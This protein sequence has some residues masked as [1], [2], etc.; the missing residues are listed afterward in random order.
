MLFLLGSCKHHHPS[1]YILNCN[2]IIINNDKRLET[3]T[4]AYILGEFLT[5]IPRPRE[6]KV[7]VAIH[8]V[9]GIDHAVHTE[10]PFQ[11]A[12]DLVDLESEDLQVV[13]V[14]ARG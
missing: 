11:V 14:V 9:P 13:P 12:F 2:E 3:E 7:A 5:A 1:L 10:R 6:E 4:C 8:V